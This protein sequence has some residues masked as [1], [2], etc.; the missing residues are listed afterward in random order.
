[1]KAEHGVSEDVDVLT[2]RDPVLIGV[3]VHSYD[4]RSQTT[5]ETDPKAS[6][7]NPKQAVAN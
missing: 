5:G 2:R 3:A 6:S 7:G 1:M 4:H